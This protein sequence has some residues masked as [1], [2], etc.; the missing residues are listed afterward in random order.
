MRQRKCLS[1]LLAAIIAALALCAC[2]EDTAPAPPDT[3]GGKM[4]LVYMVGENSLGAGGYLGKDSAE[5]M[6][7]RTYVRP[8][9]RMLF[10]VDGG[11]KPTLYRARA[12]RPTPETVAQ[13]E[14]DFCSSDPDRLREVLECAHRLWPGKELSLVLWSHADGW[15]PPTDT[16]YQRYA[17]MR[18]PVRPGIS[19]SSFG[20]D[21]GAD[22]YGSNQGAQMSVEGIASAINGAGLH[23]RYLFFDACLMQNIEVAY[24]LRHVTDYVVASPASTPGAGSNYTHTLQRGLFSD[25]PADICRTYLSDAE[26]PAQADYQGMGLVISCMR[27]D[28]V[29]A[30]ADFLRQ[31][32]PLSAIANQQS[33]EMD[34]VLAYQSY[35]RNYY[36]RPHNY[37][38]LQALH[39]I[40]PAKLH[41]DL[42]T[43]VT[44][45]VTYRGASRRLWVGPGWNE[46]QSIPVA[47]GDYCGVSLFVPQAVYTRNA[48]LTP[49]GDLNEA[50]R[51]TEWYRA[52]GFEQTGW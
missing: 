25:D 17:Q 9:D 31:A 32:L 33:A 24:A 7:G 11:G 39:H 26:D 12:D 35:S 5:I 18:Q 8:D 44:Q 28:K 45:A 34:T 16:D 10:F 49:H 3:T 20:I 43:L 22:G 23:C 30:L 2:H 15:L 51:Q 13:W 46:Y 27:T 42:R 40:L 6:N 47:S 41:N 37:D 50:F 52:A 48:A 36:Y 19:P 21:S 1:T 38:L 4:V 29:Q 14:Q